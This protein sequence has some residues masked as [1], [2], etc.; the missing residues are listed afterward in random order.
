MQSHVL[1]PYF[2]HMAEEKRVTSS[3]GNHH[4]GRDSDTLRDVDGLNLISIRYGIV[5]MVRVCH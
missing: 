1:N 3:N 5:G 4:V 2:P